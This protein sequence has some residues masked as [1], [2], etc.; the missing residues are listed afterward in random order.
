MANEKKLD[1]V[2][3]DTTDFKGD[4]KVAWDKLQKARQ[5][6]KE[7]QDNFEGSFSSAA[8]KVEAIDKEVVLAFGYRF[9]GLAIA[10]TDPNEAKS[11]AKPKLKLFS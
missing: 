6:L 9:G 7:A 11:K 5:A 4:V 10:K 3:I 1:W 2:S 8:R